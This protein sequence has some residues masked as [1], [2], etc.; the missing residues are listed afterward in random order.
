MNNQN[1]EVAELEGR[2]LGSFSYLHFF[3]RTLSVRELE[4]LESDINILLVQLKRR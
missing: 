2:L 3:H 4:G 1:I